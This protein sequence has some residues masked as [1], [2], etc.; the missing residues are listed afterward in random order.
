MG[1]STHHSTL[2][3]LILNLATGSITPQFHLVFDDMF[4]TVASSD[5]DPPDVWNRLI[6]SPSCRMRTLLDD[7]STAEL[8]DDWLTVDER[9]VRDNWNRQQAVA[10]HRDINLRP[11]MTI[12]PA[13]E[14]EHVPPI[15]SSDSNHTSSC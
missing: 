3:A 5:A 10:S 11:D 2:I 14:R 7:D 4:H 9:L 8:Y 12:T 6:D 15:G 1:F 13:I